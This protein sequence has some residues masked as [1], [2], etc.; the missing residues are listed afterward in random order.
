M[1]KPFTPK[2]IS[3]G[4][5]HL[6]ERLSRLSLL[7][8]IIDPYFKKPLSYSHAII[9][10]VNELIYHIYGQASRCVFDEYKV[11]KYKTVSLSILFT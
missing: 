5:K 1:A 8:E 11:T 9:W 4:I 10:I 3:N 2:K 7:M 6:V